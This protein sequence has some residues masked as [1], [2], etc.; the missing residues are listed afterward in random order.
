MATSEAVLVLGWHFP[1][2]VIGG[3][4]VAAGTALFVLA[5]LR[6]ADE[7]WPERTGREAARRALGAAAQPRTALVAAALVA[8]VVAVALVGLDGGTGYM[9]DYTSAAFALALVAAS[10]AAL[11]AAL[12]A[13][14][15]RRS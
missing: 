7:R 10:A 6:V 15:A 3:F 8:L 9:R 1:S 14:A 2:D 12:L 4:L 5:G 13:L 11:P